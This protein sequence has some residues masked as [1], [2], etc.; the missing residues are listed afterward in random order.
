MCES[1]CV[2]FCEM[3]V[4]RAVVGSVVGRVGPPARGQKVCTGHV[5]HLRH[6]RIYRTYIKSRMD[7]R[8]YIKS[9]IKYLHR[10]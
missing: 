1:V 9:R 2:C 7:Y 3:A 6:I 4:P 10:T 8:I 5:L